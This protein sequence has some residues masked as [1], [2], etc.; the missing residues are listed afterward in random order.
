MKADEEVGKHRKWLVER[1][2]QEETTARKDQLKFEMK[3]HEE[4]MKLQ[5]NLPAQGSHQR[6][7]S[8]KQT[9]A[10]LPKIEI[11]RF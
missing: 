6:G 3:L 4:K 2:R 1:R 5:T 8:T 9:Q 7:T 11:K 10:K